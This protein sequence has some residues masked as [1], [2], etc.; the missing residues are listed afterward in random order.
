MQFGFESDVA[1]EV[2]RRRNDGKT[3]RTQYETDW[4][5][6]SRIYHPNRQGF[7]S[8]IRR[9]RDNM[10]A[11]YNSTTL[12]TARNSVANLYSALCNPA[13]VWFQLETADP[14]LRDYGPMKKW[15]AYVSDLMLASFRP[16]VSNFY[17]AAMNLVADF[18][19]LGTGVAVDEELYGKQKIVTQPI[20]PGDCFIFVDAFGMVTEI[21]IE[22]RLTI[23]QAARKYGLENLPEDLRKKVGEKDQNTAE[24]MFLQAIQPNDDFVAGQLGNNNKPVVS[25]HVSETGKAVVKQS[26]FYEMPACA[27]RWFAD[28]GQSYGRGLGFLNLPSGKVLQQMEKDNL[29]AA[30]FAARPPIVTAG[31]RANKLM[32]QL[33]PGALMHN[34]L[35][36]QGQRLMAPLLTSQTLPISVQMTERKAKE[37]EDGWHAA[38]MALSGSRTGITDLEVM[39]RIEERLTL[40]APFMG[41][42]QTEALMPL[43]RRRFAILYRAG[44]IPRPPIDL[45]G[46]PLNITFTSIA[47]Q[48]QKASGAV[49]ARRFI[50]D[51][52]GLAQ[53][54]PSV[55]DHV[56]THQ[57]VEALA[58]AGLPVGIVRSQE[59]VDR[60]QAQRAQQQQLLEAAAV[61]QQGADTAATLA[62]AGLLEGTQ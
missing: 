42:F 13:N 30:G 38:M 49:T 45:G 59:D 3:A 57:L 4:E 14:E 41:N 50:N 48:A 2:M 7:A 27:A 20:N 32:Q 61:T 10:G 36:L 17:S 60:I 12:T 39:E 18:G 43:L 25:T 34:G 29:Q 37:V 40:I 19:I 26:G 35:S 62:N 28:T 58:G 55:M 23:V 24:Y 52:G 46:Q 56:S 8:T 6:I 16:G 22:F 15:S 31:T 11:L 44:Q 53:L 54:D 9:D 21:I 51:I 1:K 5:Q 47:A 33:R